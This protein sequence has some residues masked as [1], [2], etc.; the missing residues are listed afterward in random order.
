[1]H[2][3]NMDIRQADIGIMIVDN[4]LRLKWFNDF[5]S[6]LYSCNIREL[7]G[8]FCYTGLKNRQE[9]CP[10]CI[11]YRAKTTGEMQSGIY[12]R[13]INGLG[14]KIF[15][16][17][18][19]PMKDKDGNVVRIL[20]IAID[21]THQKD[22]EQKLKESENY[23]RTLFEH[24]GTAVCV[25]ESNKK[26]SKVNKRFEELSNYNREDIECK[27]STLD[28]VKNK[29]KVEEIHELRKYQPEI[30]PK[31]YE[32]IFVDKNGMEKVVEIYA[33][34]IPETGKIIASIIDITQHKKLEN[35]IKQ[36][37]ELLTNILENSID[38]IIG[39]DENYL[40]NSWNKASEK[41][42]SYKKEEILLCEF[43]CIL[44]ENFDLLKESLNNYGFIQDFET[45]CIT[46]DKKEKI[47]NINGALI[48][49]TEDKIIGS[50][51]IIRDITE[52]KKLAERMLYFERMSALGEL[53][54]SLAHEIKNP[55]NS[56]VINLEV[57]KGYTNKI[58]PDLKTKTEKYLKIMGE[59]I[60]RLDKVIRGFLDFAKPISYEFKK[61]NLNTIID[62][63]VE[64][65]NHEASKK[66]IKII[67]KY[68]EE[69]SIV[70][71]DETQL[72]QALLNLFLNSI[73]AM[74]NGGILEIMLNHD[75]SNFVKID[76]K[77]TGCGIAP[78]NQ[79]KIFD[80]Y[81][82]TK[83]KGSGLGLAIVKKII[84]THNGYINFKSKLNEGTT[85]TITLPIQF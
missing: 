65:I 40:I 51:L 59:E 62:K 55:L 3:K 23:Y 64:L 39:L 46:R 52:K 70:F 75:G 7:E 21:I 67:K 9:I 77:D 50:S 35:E 19:T 47:C 43:S 12:E 1:M 71:G 25:V 81:F 85:F 20:E 16:I 33:D 61:V 28:V 14:K 15:Q 79:W 6:N 5:F 18:A 78:D 32:T 2:L 11:T 48:K 24:S 73:Q 63:L 30:A 72:K 36:K 17:M 10:D 69:N 8:K 57:L 38:A 37:Q 60:E 76:V 68:Y 29:N 27:L 44:Q 56:M 45:V 31:Q 66:D 42:F 34:A 82:S 84:K 49:N 41:L 53:S 58:E 83:E 22:L 13:E 80:L 74:H 26:I 54:A 4:D